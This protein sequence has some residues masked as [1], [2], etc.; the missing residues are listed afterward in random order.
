[1]SVELPI[2]G[3]EAPPRD[4]GELVFTEPWEATA[5]GVAVALSDQGSYTWEHFRQ[6]LMRVIA[7]SEGCEAYYESWAKALEASV[8]D[9]GLI[10]ESDVRARMDTLLHHHD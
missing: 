1:M 4:N 7:A 5:F 2:S 3:E 10:S 6:R 8:I 9:A